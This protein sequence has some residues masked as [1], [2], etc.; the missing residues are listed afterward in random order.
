MI[1]FSTFFPQLYLKRRRNWSAMEIRL[2][3]HPVHRVQ[4]QSSDFN[5]MLLS[6][7]AIRLN[8]KVWIAASIQKTVPKSSWLLFSFVDDFLV[9]VFTGTDQN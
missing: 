5:F 3:I 7:I 1:I 9:Q 8:L 4:S 6:I 2:H